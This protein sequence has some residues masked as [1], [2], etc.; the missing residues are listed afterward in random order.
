MKGHLNILYEDKYITITDFCLI[1][2]KYYF[3]LATS[4]TILFNEMSQ[5]T[6]EDGSN[7]SHRWGPSTRYMNNWFHL[8]NERKRK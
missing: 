1:I 5:I 8:D 3:P 4:K 2:N 7:V 6:I